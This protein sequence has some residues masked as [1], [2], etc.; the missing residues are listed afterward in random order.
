[1]HARTHTHARTHNGLSFLPV[2]FTVVPTIR[3]TIIDS[4]LN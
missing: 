3:I 1:M 4:P 2:N